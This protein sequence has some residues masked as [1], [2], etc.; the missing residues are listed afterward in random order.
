MIH[1][2]ESYSEAF[3]SGLPETAEL[4]RRGGLSVHD[5][6]GRISLH[7][8]RGLK[9]GYRPDSDIDL[10]LIL[11]DGTL[12]G[13]SLQEQDALFLEITKATLESWKGSVELDLAL[14]FDKGG[15]RLLCF[16]ENHFNRELC[17]NHTDCFGL[18]KIQKGFSGRVP[19]CGIDT[20]LMYPAIIIWRIEAVPISAAGE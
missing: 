4:L 19:D 14:A 15:C 12:E 8:T 5:S 13:K 16:E 6:V 20:A 3:T 11:K 7:G 18:F 17:A 9:R 10:T 1:R 2:I